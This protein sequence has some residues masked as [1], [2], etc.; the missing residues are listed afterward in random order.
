MISQ[1]SLTMKKEKAFEAIKTDRV[2]NITLALTLDTR[3]GEEK[4]PVA[5]R[6]NINRKTYYYRTG[7]RCTLE[8]WEE[9]RKAKVKGDNFKIQKEQIDIYNKVKTTVKELLAV[10]AFSFDLLK[11]RLTGKSQ[12]TFSDYW[13]EF[14]K[15]KKIGTE[16]AYTIAFNSFQ[17]YV[18]SN[19]PF[20]RVGVDLIK[21]W[22]VGMIK[23]GLSNTS[24]GM[25]MR[26]CR[27]VINSCISDNKIHKNQYPFGRSA[28]LMSIK[29][30]R[31][32]TDEFISVLTIK[33]LMAFQPPENWHKCYSDA[34]MESIAFWLFSYLGNG[35]NLADMAV[36]KY[37]KHYFESGKTELKFIRQKTKDTTDE[38]IEV[39]IPIIPDLQDILNKYSSEPNEVGTL[40]FPQI[41]NGETIPDKVKKTI[42]QVNSNIRDRVQNACKE[43]GINKPISM[44]W[45]RHSFATNLTNSGVSERYISQ[46]MGHSTKSVTQGY[47][48]LFPPEKRMKFNK[49]LLED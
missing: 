41:I 18:G 8:K 22:E 35:L 19:I 5:V 16:T 32:R 34:V 33:K 29:K 48:G 11:T 12:E 39:I 26:A 9:I 24:Q 36:L 20:N 1:I 27:S 10:N 7:L 47:I 42:A 21:R 30:G 4:I 13:T 40:V 15:R 6:V 46:A 2:E 28:D 25:Y 44:T 17:K 3:K 37:D 43:I 38:D 49:M 14:A 31:S 45:A 23:D